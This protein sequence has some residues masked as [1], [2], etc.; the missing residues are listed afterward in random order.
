MPA[1]NSKYIEE[2]KDYL[3]S[4]ELEEDFKWSVEERRE[5]ILGF[6]ELLMDL[7]ELADETATKIIFKG[8]LGMLMPQKD[9]QGGKEGE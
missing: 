2:L 3:K 4:G 9:G 1:L 5:E 7:G 6:L 8:Q